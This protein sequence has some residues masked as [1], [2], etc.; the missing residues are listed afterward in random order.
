[1]SLSYLSHRQ[2]AFVGAGIGMLYGVLSM[3]PELLSGCF[4]NGQQG[5]CGIATLVF[6]MP[7][8]FPLSLLFPMS[9]LWLLPLIVL[10][11]A[12]I[13]G[14]VTWIVMKSLKS[15]RWKP[16]LITNAVLV[17]LYI[18]IPFIVQWILPTS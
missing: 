2:A 13:F 10:C 14:L 5:L 9:G 11:N 7:T 8:A 1:M 17:V 6:N 15:I 12:V 16:V 3:L 4:W 18:A